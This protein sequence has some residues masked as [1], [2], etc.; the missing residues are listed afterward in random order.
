MERRFIGISSAVVNNKVVSVRASHGKALNSREGLGF[1]EI[2]DFLFSLRAVNKRDYGHVFVCYGFSRDNEFIFSGL[3]SDIKDRIF[4]SH[5][6]RKRIDEIEVDQEYI[7][8]VYYKTTDDEERDKLAFESLVNRHA[9]LD[10]VEV[11]YEGYNI[12]LR[13]GK[14]M[15]LRKGGKQF[16][17]HDVF[18]FFRTSLSNAVATWLKAIYTPNEDAI[19][20]ATQET[21]VVSKLATK[22][23]DELEL[24][25]IKL[26]RFHGTGA[27]SSWILRTGK[28]KSKNKETNQY[29]SY[30]YRRQ[31][32]P[33]LYKAM[34]QSFYAGRAEQFKIG[35][36][37]QGVY[38]YDINSAYAYAITKLPKLL[39]KPQ[40]TRDYNHEPFS[41]WQ[42]E[43]DFSKLKNYFG[44]LPNRE[45]TS[46][47]I[48]YK[49][50][51]RGYFWQ[52]E[53]N[54]ILQH[55]PECINVGQGY[56]VEYER[57]P[58]TEVVEKIY[59]LRRALQTINHPL[60][61]ILKLSLASIYG[62]FCQA[63]GK[64]FFYNRFYAGWITSATRRQLLEATRGHESKVICFLTDAIH[65]SAPLPVPCSKELGEYKE[66]KYVRGEYIDN[67]IYRLTSANGEVKEATRGFR[68]FD[69]DLAL[70]QLNAMYSY[71][72]ES[73]MFI[74]HNLHTLSPV[75]YHDYLKMRVE[76]K[77]T[78]PLQVSTRKFDNVLT[79][80]RETYID[81]RAFDIYSGLES[82]MYNASY[83]RESDAAKDTIL[84]ERV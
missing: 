57:A 84:A 24:C 2:I 64:G 48:T 35:T 77:R 12:V 13:S 14:Q 61:K 45:K 28:A 31:L 20:R 26:Q 10:L 33:D 37:S 46:S 75:S 44:L 11:N 66:S 16:V 82:G 9:L 71:D 27:I 47:Q 81:S 36:F 59:E 21:H 43:Y 51:G 69:F 4:Q 62:K 60:E 1:K 15:I 80:L 22:L 6:V 52:P 68:L 32:S 8:D 56:F 39:K 30:R 5:H 3:P 67:G 78:N 17:L 25:G 70:D 7:D 76:T 34:M 65:T 29:H 72:G 23:N 79:N 19:I 55:Y 63:Q 18:G 73:E 41:V 38:V 49:E 53:V 83:F 74:G 40:L 54:Y 58:F 42:C 50:K